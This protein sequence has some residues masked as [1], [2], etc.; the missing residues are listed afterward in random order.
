VQATTSDAALRGFRPLSLE[1]LDAR[2]ALL[3]RVDTKYVVHASVFAQLLDAL[4]RDHDVLQI[5]DRRVFGYRSVY[6]DTAELR[7]FHDHVEDRR[8]RFKARTRCYLDA[9]ECHFEVK[10]GVGDGETD[11]RMIEHPPAADDCVTEPA[12]R[13]LDTTLGE[14]GIDPV[15]ELVPMLSTRFDRITLAAREGDSRMTCDLRLEL[16]DTDGRTARMHD[17]LVLVESKSEDGRSRPDE[18]LARMGV[19]PLALSKYRTGI[20]LL[21]EQDPTGRTQPLHRLFTPVR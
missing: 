8:P 11:K 18:V 6:F 15:G 20:D 19:A 9:G 5:D 14:A 16:A 3:R 12:R 7:C 17:D 2:A 21:I 13:L 1:A 4:A 10:L